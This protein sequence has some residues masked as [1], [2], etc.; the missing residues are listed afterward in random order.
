MK[1][2]NIVIAALAVMMAGVSCNKEQNVPENPV[3]PEGK[4][5][6]IN[7]SIPEELTKVALGY[8][9]SALALTW[10]EGDQII[11]SDHSNSGNK[12]T[13]TLTSGEGT[14][15]AKFT[16]TAVS[17]S[18][19]DIQ[20]ISNMPSAAGMLSQTQAAD[21]STAHLGYS[22]T[23]S[24][25]SSYEDVA[26]TQAWA[27]SKGGTFTQSGAL[28]VSVTLPNGVAAKVNKV[29]MKADQNIF[30]AA[31]GTMVV[32]I[33]NPG[34]AGSD[35]TFDVFATIPT[36]GVLLPKDLGILFKF[37]TTDANHDVYTRYYQTPSALTLAPGQLNLI[38]LTGTNSDKYAGKNDDGT[39]E[40][41]Y[42][43]ADKYQVA[44]INSLAVKGATTYFKMIDDVDMTGATHTPIND[45]GSTTPTYNRSV[46]FDG[47]GKTISNL[48]FNL[49]YVFKGSIKN[50]TLSGCSVGNKRGIFAEYC[51][52]EGNTITNVD[53]T[54]CSMASTSANSGA[55]I[56]CINS[57]G[58]SATITDCTV[59][60]TNVKGAGVAGGLIGFADAVV[61]VSGC[62]YTGGTVETTAR[63]AGGL[64]GSASNYNSV[65]SNCQVEDAEIKA[66]VASN[67]FRAGGLIGQQQTKVTVKG[68]SV[69]KSDKKVKLTLA[70]PTSGKVYNSGGFVGVQ[71][72]TITKNDDDTRNTAFVTITAENTEE[73]KQMNL[74]GFVGYNTGSTAYC[75]A[76]VTGSSLKGTHI[77]GFA[78]FQVSGSIQN[79]TVSG[80]I[81]GSQKTGGFV[82][83][84][85]AGSISDC[86]ATTVV[87][88]VGSGTD[89]GGFVGEMTQA[90]ALTKCNAQGAV[91]VNTNYVGGFAGA[92]RPAADK[93]ASISKCW[94]S[95]VVTSS[96][97][98]CGS[99]IGH[100]YAAGTVQISDSY[101]TGNLVESNQRQGG[102]IG[103]ITDGTITISRCYASGT[104]TGSFA[105]G[106][107][108]GYMGATATVE[109]CAAWNSSVT[110]TS[111]GSANWSSAAVIGVA[112]PTAT[113]TDNYR[114]P[115]MT[116]TAYWVPATDYNHPN[117][118]STHP[119]VKQNGSGTTATSPA[120]GQDGYPQFPYHG[121]VE[122]GKTLSELASTTLGWS[123]EIWDFSTALP[124][125]K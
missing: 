7:A 19:F 92:V 90:V 43:I 2:I 42:L 1:K 61:T 37:G 89:F 124:T 96:S 48:G 11:V 93:T 32:N 110:P 125:L 79:S 116:L 50:L 3:G 16:G 30:G 69:G 76:D 52:G 118:S 80:T 77:G 66:T 35:N 104:V 73:D 103:Q 98:Q 60:G 17:A 123:S 85:Q 33:T 8:T 14:K 27:T 45:D 36:T 22:A 117:V 62:K 10:Q 34:D 82:G 115:G 121:K 75:D 94:S 21:G 49:F 100:I 74:G 44:A 53:I 47:N 99:F 107:L 63:F 31:G 28:H 41:P 113:L 59:S 91:T 38:S 84:A 108:I 78:G 51:Q 4:T 119:L 70:A 24:G 25:V 112:F 12:Q 72:G 64:I 15:N 81:T 65:I 5:V 54:G 58:T 122:A 67:D 102:F 120:K 83:V 106:G 26:F 101:S 71:Y 29:T 114:N 88:K 86:S 56:G 57:T 105:I 87:S 68:C 13:F 109:K 9:G 95:G 97:A 39:A 18:S 23:L 6:T 40:K 111:Y 46:N 20:L 55:L